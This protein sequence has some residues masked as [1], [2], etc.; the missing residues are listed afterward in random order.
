ML[1]TIIISSIL[2]AI[3]GLIVYRII[4]KAR[5][6]QGLCEGCAY[7]ETCAVAK[8]SSTKSVNDCAERKG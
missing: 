2:V 5:S 8:Y 7:S 4:K 6:A 3:V 1:A